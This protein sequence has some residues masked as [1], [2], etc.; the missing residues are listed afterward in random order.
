MISPFFIS[1]FPFPASLAFFPLS[2]LPSLSRPLRTLFTFWSV[3][4]DV[5]NDLPKR[6][7]GDK[8]GERAQQLPYR[9]YDH[10]PTCQLK[11]E[12]GNGEAFPSFPFRGRGGGREGGVPGRGRRQQRRMQAILFHLF[13]SRGCV[14]RKREGAREGR[15]GRTTLHP[16]LHHSFLLDQRGESTRDE[17]TAVIGQKGRHILHVQIPTPP[18]ANHGF[19]PGEKSIGEEGGAS[20]GGEGGRR[21]G[22]EGG[23]EG[24]R[25]KRSVHNEGEE[26]E[27]EEKQVPG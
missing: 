25:V 20:L 24:K 27:E 1:I 17:R 2:L 8:D 26:D 23:S 13:K 4:A 18:L 5:G 21:R 10:L 22:R 19:E 3:L 14:G 12:E 9:L 6:K 16:A 11:E 7:G 15:R